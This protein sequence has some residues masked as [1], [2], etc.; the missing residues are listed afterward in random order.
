MDLLMRIEAGDDWNLLFD[1][2]P[3]DLLKLAEQLLAAPTPSSHAQGIRIVAASL[4]EE[5]LENPEG[6]TRLAESVGERLLQPLVAPLLRVL[7]DDVSAVDALF[8]LARHG[9]DL[10]MAT[11]AVVPLLDKA[12]PKN[13]RAHAF[14]VRLHAL[15]RAGRAADVV[16]HLKGNAAFKTILFH[17]LT[18]YAARDYDRTPFLALVFKEV[19]AKGE[20]TVR[21]A[22]DVLCDLAGAGVDIGLIAAYLDEHIVR[23][24]GYTEASR[25]LALHLVQQKDRAALAQWIGSPERKKQLCA[26]RG[27]RLAAKSGL[28]V[29]VV[30]AD[31]ELRAQVVALAADPNNRLPGFY[32]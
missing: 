26:Y 6:A 22:V 18:A 2:Q 11:E 28:D 25:A 24:S 9:V 20:S 30:M 19:Q 10:T 32:E 23:L 17:E 31:P 14:A 16:V 1:E 15:C 4:L 13:V 5:E 12:S 21:G 27:I 3:S 8:A 29:S 7:A